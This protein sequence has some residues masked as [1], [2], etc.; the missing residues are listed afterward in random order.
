MS[1]F[2]KSL[3]KI[4]IPVTLQCMLQSSF[5]IVDQLMIGQLGETSIS[6]VGLGGNFS[7]IYSVVSGAVAS[8]AG[9]IIAQFLGANDKKEAWRGFHVSM[10]AS[11]LIAAVFLMA[12]LFAAPQILSLYTEDLAIVAEGTPYFQ[13]VAVAYLPMAI[14]MILSTWLRCKEHATIPLIASFGSVILN[15]GLNYVFIFGKLGYGAMGVRGAAFATLI[16]QC[17]NMLFIFVG[18]LVSLRK[19]DEK[20]FFSLRLEKVS[21]K[22]YM[23]M[24]SPILISE[25]LWSLGQNV[26]SGVFGHLSTESLAAYTLTCPIQGLV[27]GALSGLAAAAG[28]MIGKHLGAKEYDLA[29]RDSKKIMVVGLFGAGV[30]AVLLIFLSDFYV[31]FYKVEPVVRTLGKWILVAFALYAPVKVENMILGGGILKSGGDTKTVMIIDLV[32]TWLIGVPLCFFAAYVLQ[33]QIVGV[34]ALFTV[35]EVVRL[36]I[37]LVVFGRRNWMRSLSDN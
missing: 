25:F 14:S 33:L 20:L 26:E 1:A 7:L 35:E 29:Y 21:L 3:C 15:T 23:V 30:L 34:Y 19:D 11:V 37:S 32:G 13:V 18:F 17:A 36:V 12:S 6:A 10:I 27:C 2:S 24:I 4:A 8:V 9:I 16:S 5:S 28:V 22:E 31:S